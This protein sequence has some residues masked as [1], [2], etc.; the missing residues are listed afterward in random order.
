MPRS[1]ATR[2]ADLPK[3]TLRNRLLSSRKFQNWA[4]KFPV[5]RRFVRRD[6]LAI[7]DLV[8][9]FCHSQILAAL[10]ELGVLE[11]LRGAPRSSNDLAAVCN[12][13][14]ARM[15]VLLR[16]GIS[17]GLLRHKRRDRYGLT[18]KG[19]ALLG[20][21][22]LSEM[23]LHHRVLYRDLVDPAA[24]FKGETSPKLASFWPYVFG[25]GAADDSESAAR[26]SNL[27]AES[28]AMVA[29]D[30]LNSVPLSGVSTLMDI[31]GGTGAFL[32]AAGA[33][34][35]GLNLHLFDLPAVVSGAQ[36]RFD[37]A[38]LT[39]R[40]TITKGSFRDD[41]LPKGADAISLVRVLY[42][43]SDDTVSAL[44]KAVRT[45][46]PEDGL[47]LI[48]E[49]MT[50]GDRPERAGDAYFALYTM[51]MGTGRTRSAAEIAAL[52]KEAG[53]SDVRPRKSTRPF[54]TSCLTAR[55]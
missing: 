40:T 8:A 10:V 30:T 13:P 47:L 11:Q 5:I 28:Q 50:G 45:A 29:E 49:P 18:R 6:G 33:K 26:Y 31:G 12:V 43:H 15:K 37:A 20:V 41:V 14:P 44:L 16:A 17:L 19:A 27:M 24:F 51:A 36:S 39:S 53:F 3:A 23:I 38:G 1:P 52:C 9:G 7:F 46:L 48:S 4:A 32:T 22:G 21:P 2:S 42:D 34:Y 35:P 54:I 25:A 55:R